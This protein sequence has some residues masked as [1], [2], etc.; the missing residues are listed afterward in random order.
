VY[1]ITKSDIENK[2][3]KQSE[4]WRTRGIVGKVEAVNLQTSQVTVEISSLTGTSKITLTPKEKAKFL[5]Y[6]PDSIRFDEAKDSSLADVKI[7][8]SLRALG[9]K[10]ADGMGFVAEQVL[11]GSF[12]TIA[13]TVKFV[14]VEKNEVIIKDLRTN[15]EVAVVMGADSRLKRFP[16]E[17]AERMAG[18]QM[19]GGGVRP[20]GQRPEGQ[21]AQGTGRGGSG[22]R[23]SGGIDDMFVRFP[24]IT[25]AD[26]K[27]GDMIAVSSTKNTTADR[28]TA[29][30]L[31]A[32]VEPFIRAAA[33]SGGER[34]GRGGQSLSIPGL[35]GLDFP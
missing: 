9:D 27:A 24:D 11:T 10:S 29:I 31:V 4:E 16:A 34:R 22:G 5:R 8:D 21:N 13:G 3:A 20:V 12:Q 17:M 32:G 19:G 6:A 18:R 7:G 25:T 1:F 35:N 15:R 23:P 30:K 33:A 14:D 28:I 26:L 2:N